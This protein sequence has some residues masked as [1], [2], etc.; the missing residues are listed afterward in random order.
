MSPDLSF[1]IFKITRGPYSPCCDYKP[2]C[3][4]MK[5]A[6]DKSDLQK[7]VAGQGG[8]AGNRFQTPWFRM[9]CVEPNCLGSKLSSTSYLTSLYHS[10]LICK[11][12]ETILCLPHGVAGTK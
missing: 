11:I 8:L 6:T 9:C 12:G 1:L 4:S 2:G 7:Q 3:G 10:F 5:A